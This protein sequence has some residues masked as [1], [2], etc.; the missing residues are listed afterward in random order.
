MSSP[1][2]PYVQQFWLRCFGRGKTH[3]VINVFDKRTGNSFLGAVN[4]LAAERRFYDFQ[5]KGMPMTLESSLAELESETA[6][7]VKTILEKGRL[8]VK[9]PEVIQERGTIIRF[10]AVQMVR[11]AG[12]LARANDL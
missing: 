5:F 2:H 6:Q 12:A 9:E 3:Q 10:L 11:T 8:A 1:L 4:K 7:C